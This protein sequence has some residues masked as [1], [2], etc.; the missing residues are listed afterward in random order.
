MR[1]VILKWLIPDEFEKIG[2]GEQ[3][4]RR[5]GRVQADYAFT[6]V[7]RACLEERAI[8][9]VVRAGH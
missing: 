8:V 7:S 9:T 5:I 1:E 3:H 2:R 6:G 4:S